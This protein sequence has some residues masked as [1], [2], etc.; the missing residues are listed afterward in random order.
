MPLES[1]PLSGNWE[2]DERAGRANGNEFVDG[3]AS[4]TSDP[5]GGGYLGK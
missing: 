3:M 2:W 5:N 4:L 1:S